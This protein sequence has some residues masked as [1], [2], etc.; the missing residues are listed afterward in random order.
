MGYLYQRKQRDGERGGPWWI[1]YYVNGRPTR[2]STAQRTMPGRS[3]CSKIV[4]DAQRR[5]Y[6]FRVGWTASAM[7]NSP[8]C[9]AT[10]P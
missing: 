5:A 2:E 4:R 3:A 7:R 9:G 1:K 6:R 10:T 8:I